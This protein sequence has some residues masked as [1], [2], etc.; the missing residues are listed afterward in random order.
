MKNCS[1]YDVVKMEKPTI[2]EDTVN[3]HLDNTDSDSE[4]QI[5]LKPCYRTSLRKLGIGV[6]NSINQKITYAI[7]E[8]IKKMANL[9]NIELTERVM[10]PK[11]RSSTRKK[12]K[13][14]F[15]VK[16]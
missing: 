7:N 9:Q 16:N 3:S 12:I 6:A 5:E 11:R 15:E 1:I 8:N 10:T 2:P 14:A 4:E 13:G